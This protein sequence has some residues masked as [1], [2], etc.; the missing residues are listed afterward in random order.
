LY[1]DGGPVV[2]CV[3]T[4]ENK[5][6]RWTSENSAEILIGKIGLIAFEHFQTKK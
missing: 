4:A 6:K 2:I 5:D 1:F 3:L